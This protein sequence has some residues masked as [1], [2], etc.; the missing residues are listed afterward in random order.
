MSGSLH[1]WFCSC[2]DQQKISFLAWLSH[3][4]TIHGR[5]FGLDHRGDVVVRAFKGLNEL[6]HQ[7]SQ[8]IG[9]LNDRTNEYDGDLIWRILYDTAARHGLSA[10]LQ[11]SLKTFAGR[12]GLQWPEPRSES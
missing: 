4:L 10:H 1:G 3:D 7:I 8:N 5:G 2:S 11:S 12:H 9:H 6:Q